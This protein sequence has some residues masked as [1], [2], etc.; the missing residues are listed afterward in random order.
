MYDVSSPTTRATLHEKVDAH[1]RRFQAWAN[2]LDKKQCSHNDSRRWK[3]RGSQET[4]RSVARHIKAMREQHGTSYALYK[5]LKDYH[6]CLDTCQVD[7]L[8][9]AKASRQRRGTPVERWKAE[10]EANVVPR[11]CALLEQLV[12]EH[13][14]REDLFVLSLDGKELVFV[15][16]GWERVEPERGDDGSMLFY[17]LPDR[18]RF[19]R[20]QPSQQILLAGKEESLPTSSAEVAGLQFHAPACSHT[21]TSPRYSALSRSCQRVSANTSSPCWQSWRTLLPDM[22][23]RW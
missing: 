5:A 17:G 21:R 7:A 15:G 22:H 20:P 3:A 8:E 14:P 16:R 13:A 1:V 9:D 4:L 2:A 12:N 19:S 23:E 18:W 10:G 11:I 6:E